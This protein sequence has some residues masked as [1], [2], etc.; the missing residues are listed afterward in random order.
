MVLI[1]VKGGGAAKP[2]EADGKRLCI[3]KRLYR[4][5]QVVLA[6]WN[7]GHE[8]KFYLLRS[9]QTADPIRWKRDWELAVDLRA[10]FGPP[11]NR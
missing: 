9:R 1:Q 2:T 3:V 6:T 8:A 11:A 5:G 7:K 4:A 10:V